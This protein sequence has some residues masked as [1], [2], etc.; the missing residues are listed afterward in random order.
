GGVQTTLKSRPFLYLCAATFLVFNGFILIAA[1]QSYVVI[2]YIFG[3]NEALGAEFVFY[4]GAAGAIAGFGIVL[5][6]A[7][8][9]TQ[10][11]KRR[12]LMVC[13]VVSVVGYLMK[14]FAY[15]P[16]N[17]WL[18]L[19]P[20]P[21]MAFGFASLFTLVPAMVADVVDLDELNT[22]ERREGT[23]GSIYWWIVKL[24]LAGALAAGGVLLNVTGFDVELGGAQ[25]ERTLFLLRVFD[26]AIP[27][28]TSAVAIWAIWR[29]PITEARALAIRKELEA[30]RGPVGL[31]E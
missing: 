4:A 25:T 8:L 31:A 14:W 21:F 22:H 27:A 20:A 24:G 9:G 3:G 30:R 12:A 10:I 7:W 23:Y 13:I 15:D 5:L 11:G 18:V 28:L 1:F 19:L 6:S 2:Y 17:P 29:Y 16:A 26:V